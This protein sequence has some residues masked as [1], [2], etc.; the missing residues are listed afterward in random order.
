EDFE[1]ISSK[2]DLTLSLG[3]DKSGLSGVLEYATDLFDAS[4]AERFAAHLVRVLEQVVASPDTRLGDLDLLGEEERHRL[5]VT[6]NETGHQVRDATVVE[7]FEAQA[8]RA[9][10]ATAVVF[11]DLTLSYGELNERSNQLAHHLRN[12]GVGPEKLVAIC[13]E[14]SLDMVVGLLA[15]L[16]S[17]GAYVPLDPE[18]P[19]ERLLFMLDDT[20]APILL[21]QERLL[22]RL[23]ATRAETI[24]L[25]RDWPLISAHPGSALHIPI[26]P[27]NLVYVTYTSGSTGK[28][29]GVGMFHRG[30][31]N[32]MDW[33]STVSHGR[34][35]LQ[36]ASI[37]FDQSAL[38][39]LSSLFSGGEL[40]IV[41]EEERFGL[42]RDLQDFA[43]R[44]I[45]D[46]FC[47]QSVLDAIGPLP[48]KDLSLKNIIQ[49]GEALRINSSVRE[50]LAKAPR[51]SL[52][53][54]YGPTETHVVTASLNVEYTFDRSVPIGRPIWNT[55]VY[56][57]DAFLRP[58]PAGV[59]GELYIAG[60]GLARGYLNRHGLTAERFVACPFKAPGSRMYRTGDLARWRTDGELEFLGRND[61]QVKIR[62]FRIELGEIEAVLSRQP[63]VSQAA[64]IAREDEP[65]DKRLA[66]YLVAETGTVLDEKALQG[67]L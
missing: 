34:R 9:P 8:A 30:L 17:G 64:V 14:R 28:P 19:A 10:D 49:T 6:W 63:G 60:E 12:L 15:V 13:I 58:V 5:L 25:D 66:A 24:C 54:Y 39:I 57:L 37:G 36:F 32:L 4:T 65:G 42:L 47:A 31:I 26:D 21:T 40:V 18:Y 35:I 50:L 41:S 16:K 7:L 51:A 46:V 52:H 11:G 61:F 29:K 27:V 44:Q 56:V 48:A 45:E 33:H 38:E 23:P 20:A 59:A 53:N 62:G 43:S 67:D 2:F 22:E 3:E 55:E 1:W